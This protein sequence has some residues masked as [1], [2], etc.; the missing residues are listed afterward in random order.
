MFVFKFSDGLYYKQP[1]MANI[2]SK[3]QVERWKHWK[4]DRYY[5]DLLKL[6]EE[7]KTSNINEAKLFNSHQA[8]RSSNAYSWGG[9]ILEVKVQLELV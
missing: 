6:V 5:N 9:D 4:A 2:S 8:V 3:E 1:T 7:Y